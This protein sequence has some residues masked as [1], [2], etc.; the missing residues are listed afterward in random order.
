MVRPVV[1]AVCSSPFWVSGVDSDWGYSGTTVVLAVD[2]LLSICSAF[3]VV[4]GHWLLLAWACSASKIMAVRCP[5][6]L[7]VGRVSEST[8]AEPSK[9]WTVARMPFNS[10]SWNICSTS[11]GHSAGKCSLPNGGERRAKGC[12]RESNTTAQSNYNSTCGWVGNNFRQR[13]WQAFCL[14]SEGAASDLEGGLQQVHGDGQD[15]GERHLRSVAVI[16]IDDTHLIPTDLQDHRT[17]PVI[18]SWK[19]LNNKKSNQSV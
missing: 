15:M 12:M 8:L 19:K 1:A 7:L 9:D 13:E 18:V 5:P 16:C 10:W 3:W 6:P 14:T 2:V 4:D 17:V 11:S